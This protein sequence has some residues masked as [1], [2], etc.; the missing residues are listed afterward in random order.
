V[1]D[2]SKETGDYQS[3]SRVDLLVMAF[4]VKLARE[5]GEFEKV[6]LKPKKLEEFRPKS[7]KAHYDQAEDDGFWNDSDSEGEGKPKQAASGGEWTETTGA[8]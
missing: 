2:F 3:L 8:A 4:G 6:T 7:F 5:K 1:E